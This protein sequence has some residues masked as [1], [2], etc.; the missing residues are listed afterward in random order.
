[1][2]MTD[3]DQPPEAIWLDSEALESHFDAVRS[4]YRNPAGGEEMEM[5]PLEQNELTRGL[6]GG[7]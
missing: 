5:V 4:K 6:R 2:E 1:M 3:E 7:R